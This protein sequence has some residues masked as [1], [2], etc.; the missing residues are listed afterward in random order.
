[1]IAPRGGNSNI[2]VVY[3]TIDKN[4]WNREIASDLKSARLWKMYD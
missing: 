4:R 2:T 3:N 1:M